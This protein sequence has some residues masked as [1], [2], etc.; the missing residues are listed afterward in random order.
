MHI[1]EYECTIHYRH[2]LDFIFHVGLAYARPQ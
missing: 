1:M 2:A